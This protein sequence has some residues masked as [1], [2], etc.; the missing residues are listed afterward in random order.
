MHLKHLLFIFVL[1]LSNYSCKEEEEKEPEK[2]ISNI[3]GEEYLAK[4]E[5]DMNAF[6]AAKLVTE[7]GTFE[8]NISYDLLLSFADSL[9]S[10]TIDSSERDLYFRALNTV[11]HEFDKTDYIKIGPGMFSYFLHY[12]K[13]FTDKLNKESGFVLSTWTELLADQLHETIKDPEIS[14]KSVINVALKHCATC[15]E[16]DQ[17][18]ILS[19][20]ESL[21]TMSE[22]EDELS[23]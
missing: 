3:D 17:Q 8:E 10:T 4:M 7:G 12:P 18:F 23:E 2:L 16:E 1:I 13:E 14:E 21:K 20:V 22:L 11:L 5:G 15:T 6:K 19:F 9:S